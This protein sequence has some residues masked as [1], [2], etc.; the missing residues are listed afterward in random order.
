MTVANPP[1]ASPFA[2]KIRPRQLDRLAIVYIRQSTPHQ[3]VS[4]RESADLQYQ[5]RRRAVSLGW[6]EDRVLVIDDDQGISG[7][8]VENRPGFQRLLAEVS[9]GHVGIVFGREMSRLA[10]SCKDWHQLLELC[11]LFQALIGDADGVYDPADPN[12]RMLLGLRG[13]MSEAELHVLR[14]RLHQGKLNKARRGELF[15][16]VPIGYVRTPDG[17]IAWDPDE[18]VR[19]VVALVFAKFA[20]L[21]SLTKTHAFLVAN[22]VQLGLRV[23]KGANKGQLVW[24]RPRR[25]TLYEMLRN[26]FY[27]GAYAYGRC[28]VN[29]TRR[30]P[31]KAK[32]GRRTAPPDE[33]VCL[34]RDKVPAYISWDQYEE[35]RRRLAANDRGRGSKVAT[36]R[37]PTLLN[38]I[39]RCGHC[40]RPML[41]HN[42]RPTANPRY[43]CAHEFAEY[44]GPRCQS[45]TAAY[46]DRLIEALVLRAVEPA[47]LELSLRAAEQLEQDRERVHAHWR[48]R[49]E[50]ADYEVS[51]ARRQ[52]DVVDPENRLVA[53]E[54]EWQW[55]QKLAQRQRLQEDYSRFQSQRPRHLTAADRERIRGLAADLPALWQAAT[56]TGADRRAVVRLLIERVEL[57]RHG[58]SERVGIVVHWRG[59]TVTRHEITQGL[60]SYTALDRY[61]ELRER[62]IA[63]RG[64]GMTA[65]QLA[66][67]LNREGY[68]VPRGKE[69]TGHRVRQL[70]ARFGLIGIPAGVRGG[71]DLPAAGEWWLPALA[72]ELG[73]KPIVVHRWRWSGWVRARQ[74]PGDNGR[75]IVWAGTAEIKRLRRLRA[76]EITHHGRRT[77]PTKL[78]TPR[79][80]GPARQRTTAERSGGK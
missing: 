23:Y 6:A 50:R 32:A 59:G 24:Q 13:M 56:T 40:G 1:V 61:D 70:F 47:A 2:H 68:V 64:E 39:V 60:R 35:N 49:L 45:V 54:L 31:G 5:L 25:S 66:Q 41:A 16:C 46:T 7:Q 75:W 9:L 51:R 78:I 62:V 20:E 73:V 43:A 67:A 17:G 10:R 57:T 79:E 72:V 53:R 28:P 69:Y 80:P 42:A 26:P 71:R 74:L 27:A 48:Q 52:Y 29:P 22:G 55:E 18:Q 11:G 19:S 58:E 34:L 36:G 33:W 38:G 21:G 15:T 14:S 44:G 3:V 65:D 12:D 76:F 30:T 77:P 4:N 37:A 63:L 8:S